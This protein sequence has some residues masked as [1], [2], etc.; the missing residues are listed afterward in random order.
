MFE[1]QVD[2]SN[3]VDSI[4][5]HRFQS[6]KEIMVQSDQKLTIAMWMSTSYCRY[7]ETGDNYQDIENPDKGLFTLEESP[8]STNSTRIG[9]GIIPGFLYRL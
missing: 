8:L 1:E 4:I 2:R 9:R 6:V 7:S 3:A 5:Q